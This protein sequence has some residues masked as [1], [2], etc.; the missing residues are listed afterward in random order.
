MAAGLGKRFGSTKQITPVGPNGETIMDYSVFDALAAGFTRAVFIIRREIEDEF[1][2]KF[3]NRIS[4]KIN[5]TYVF[6]DTPDWRQKPLGT[7]AA[8]LAASNAVSG[9]FCLINADDLYGADAFLQIA[10]FFKRNQTGFALVAYELQNTMS[11]FGQVSRGV[12]SIGKHAKVLDIRENGFTR[13]AASAQNPPPFVSVNCF[14]F[15]PEIFSH[16][17]K[18]HR[19]FLSNLGSDQNAESML[20][21]HIGDLLRSGAISIRALFTKG[22][23]H[24]VTYRDDAPALAAH[25]FA[26]YP[27]PLWG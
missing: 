7:T 21:N 3:F 19:A 24:G 12:L 10:K 9:P 23:W 13:D 27:S 16:L 22:S 25:L 4:T 8:L 5:G 2:A 14:A 26:N 11:N 20:S 1:K 17:E 6:Q 18:I 15:T